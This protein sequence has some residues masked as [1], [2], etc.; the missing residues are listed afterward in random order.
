MIYQ[1]DKRYG[2]QVRQI[3]D[4]VASLSRA[5]CFPLLTKLLTKRDEK[6]ETEKFGYRPSSTDYRGIW[7]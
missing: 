6:R 5:A 1:G 7:S 4:N 3:T 2:L